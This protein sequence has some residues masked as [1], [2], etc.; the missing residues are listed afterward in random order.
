MRVVLHV[1]LDAFFPSVEV[2]EHPEYN[3]K[4]VVVGADPKE[5]KGRGVVSSASYEARKFGIRSAMPISGAWNVGDL[6]VDRRSGLHIDYF[7][8]SPI[9]EH[10]LR[11]IEL[12]IVDSYFVVLVA[13]NFKREF[14]IY[15]IS[16]HSLCTYVIPIQVHLISSHALR[17]YLGCGVTCCWDWNWS[18]DD[19]G[20]LVRLNRLNWRRILG[21]RGVRHY[22]YHYRVAH[23]A[24]DN[25]E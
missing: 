14:S 10:S 5:G 12:T 22:I 13:Y 25:E 6:G 1:D 3:G 17:Y 11:V 2:R 20:L 21:N 8:A 24:I 18:R 7:C 15:R 16:A 19:C 9:E 23:P 4:P